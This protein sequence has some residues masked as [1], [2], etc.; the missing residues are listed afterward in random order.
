MSLSRVSKSKASLSQSGLVLVLM[1]KRGRKD[2]KYSLDMSFSVG[3]VCQDSGVSGSCD[4]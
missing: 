4:E 3:D 2:L 1:D